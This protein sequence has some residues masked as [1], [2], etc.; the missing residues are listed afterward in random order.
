MAF[1]RGV[2][3]RSWSWA[4]ASLCSAGFVILGASMALAHAGG[5]RLSGSAVIQTAPQ[6]AAVGV[7]TPVVV[8]VVVAN[9][10][11]LYGADVQLSF[12]P[13]IVQVVDA[14]GVAA[15]GVQI[16]HGSLLTSQGYYFVA[17][18][19][20]DNV[21][22][23]ISFAITQ[24]NPA[25]PVSGTGP[26]CRITF[27]AQATG[28]SPVHFTRAVLAD[29]DGRSIPFTFQDGSIAVG[30]G[31]PATMTATQ[32][33]TPTA[34]ATPTASSTA[35]P[36]PTASSTLSP[37]VTPSPTATLT[38]SNTP[39]PS[40]T[41]TPT[42][43][44]TATNS[45]TVTQTPTPT[46]AATA[47]GTATQTGTA[48]GTPTATLTPLPGA[49]HTSTATATPSWTAT[50]T[51][52]TSPTA[53]Q[54]HT[55]TAT[56]TESSTP[57]QSPTASPTRTPTHTEAPDATATAT[58]TASAQPSPTRTETPSPTATA[59]AQPSPT[60]TETPSPTATATVTVTPSST[61][62]PIYKAYLP[63][64]GFDPPPPATATATLTPAATATV[65]RSLDGAPQMIAT[66][67]VPGA[68]WV[69]V[70][71]Q[72][73]TAYVTSRSDDCVYPVDVEAFTVGECIPVGHMPFGIA[74][75]AA[76]RWLY[77]AD[78]GSGSVS[79]IN[80]DSRSVV[81]THYP[82]GSPALIAVDAASG[83]AYVTLH[84][85]SLVA[86]FRGT[87]YLG[88]FDI[89]AEQ[90]F[91]IAVDSAAT[92][93][94]LYI[95][96]REYPGRV[97][98][99]TIDA[100]PPRYLSNL[101][102]GGSVYNLAVSPATGRMFVMHTARNDNDA[103]YMA[104]YD[105]DGARLSGLAR[106]DTGTN[107]FDGGGLAVLPCRGDRVYAAGTDCIPGSASNCAGYA[108]SG[109]IAVLAETP[110]TFLITVVLPA[111]KT[112]PFGIATDGIRGRI[113]VTSKGDGGWLNVLEDLSCA[114]A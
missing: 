40:P 96:T 63:I 94:R 75:D 44:N 22:G 112:G 49:T 60:H 45:P 73:G 7:G 111:V 21:T 64:V 28:V 9:V 20:A 6:S 10:V 24:F 62:R 1:V 90:A 32:T 74:A 43:T 86:Y 78:F 65:T 33:R 83:V 54:T 99:Y 56:P 88:R 69:A 106:E 107:T 114:G 70:D 19:R 103:R 97:R 34:T 42:A 101:E 52:T 11:D 79:I 3:W 102:P 2:R 23:T 59:S 113:Y 38:A 13:T 37:S 55:S 105:R 89:G 57:T 18:N 61:A 98:V 29:R 58:A 46:L 82:G 51:A 12:D 66:I 48:T 8:D 85:T 108:E 92:P 26:L 16:A 100:M 93:R 41:L 5:A 50:P 104:I 67:A 84:P 72:T 35:S 77:V 39:S 4:L 110:G 95:G 15:N 47:T 109:S 14:D 87:Q 17:M 68:N 31:A 25:L 71:S 76:R 81:A 53:T 80:M 30:G 27:L 91:S 36:T